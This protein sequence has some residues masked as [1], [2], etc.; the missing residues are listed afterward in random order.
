M[1]EIRDIVKRYDDTTVLDCPALDLAGPGIIALVG[2][3][4]AG[5]STLLSIIGRLIEPTSG[6]VAVDGLD[7]ATSR[8]RDLAGRLA[9]LRQENNVTVRLTVRELVEFGRFPYS[10]GRLTSGDHAA[11]DQALDTLELHEFAARRLDELSGGQRQRAFIA[12]VVAQD[13]DYVLLD[14]PLN[15]LDLRH[16]TQSMAMIHRLAHDLG[17]TV[18][19]VLH[20]VNVAS[21]HA[22]RVI[23]MRGGRVVADGEPGEVIDTET[24][25]EVFG[26]DVAV[27]T[28]A[29]RPVVLHFVPDR[30]T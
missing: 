22:D 9:V 25:A 21:H 19:V 30:G 18:V 1:I 6:T 12:A 24:M 8:G 23:A 17:K 4:G 26:I 28:V 29:G 20:D 7:V 15:N 5:K 11:V 3:N 13:T 2:A 16:Q 27:T 14:E 10:R